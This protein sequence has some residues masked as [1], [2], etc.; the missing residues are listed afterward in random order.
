M[1]RISNSWKL[2]KTSFSILR[3]DKELLLFPFLSLVFSIIVFISFIGGFWFLITTEMLSSSYAPMFWVL[4]FLLYLGVYFIILFFNTAVIGC[5]TIRLKG[6][7]PTIHDGLS[8]A[9]KHLGKIFAWAIISA[10]IGIILNVIRQRGGIAGKAVSFV[11]GI[12]WTYATF[13]IIPVMIY[14]N[15]GVFKSIRRSAQVF[16]DAWG[17]TFV[18]SFGFGIIFLLLGLIGIIFI[19]LGAMFGF[20]GLIVGLIVSVVYWLIIGII[21]SA[22]SSIYVSALYQYATEKKLPNGFDAVMMPP[23]K[24]STQSF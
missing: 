24:S 7:D 21:A 8:I 13:F 9:S 2:M 19:I 20:T 16:K 10:T 17:E 1:G 23:L 11:S 22:I 15:Q 12:A 14:E 5:A 18:G 6:G 3:K 4:I